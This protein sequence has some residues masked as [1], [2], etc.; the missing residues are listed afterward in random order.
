MMEP[1]KVQFFE[2]IGAPI[3]EK[4]MRIHPQVGD[5]VKVSSNSGSTRYVVDE[6]FWSLDDVYVTEVQ[7][8]LKRL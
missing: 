3:L 7:I 8:F 1:Y 4:W 2:E 5:R 6:V